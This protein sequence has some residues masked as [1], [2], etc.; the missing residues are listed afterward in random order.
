[1][2]IGITGTDGAGKGTVVEHLKT[3]GFTHYSARDFIEAEIKRQGLPSDRNQMRLTANELRAKHGNEYVV[4]QAYEKAIAEGE[5][6]VVIE[7]LRAVAEAKYLK[8][9]GGV[10][11]AVDADPGVRYQRVQARRSASDQV[12]YEQFLEHEALEKNDPDP[13]GMQKAAVM[14]MADHT[15]MN[16][17]TVEELEQKVETFLH[18]ITNHS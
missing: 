16:D 13:N 15:I 18:Q 12:S 1:M 17:G 2:I 11:L 5:T 7:S 4:K 3:K 6:K 8:Q 10:L 9:Q 14:E